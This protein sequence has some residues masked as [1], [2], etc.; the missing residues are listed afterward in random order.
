MSDEKPKPE[1]KPRSPVERM[2]VWGGI[3]VLLI[4]VLVELRAQQGYSTTVTKLQDLTGED[5]VD[6]LLLADAEATLSWSP[7]VT[8]EET[9]TAINYRYNWESVFKNGQFVL[10]FVASKEEPPSLLRFYTGDEDPMAAQPNENPTSGPSAEEA[11]KLFTTGGGGG[12]GGGGSR[13]DPERP[14]EDEGTSE[15]EPAKEEPSEEEP[16][17]EEPA[18]EEPAKEGSSESTGGSQENDGDD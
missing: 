11:A 5:G 13:E 7:T 9:N 14:N 2:I 6:E 3:A 12:G 15:E 18:K 16:A 4:L 10:H 17:K 8:T 1:K